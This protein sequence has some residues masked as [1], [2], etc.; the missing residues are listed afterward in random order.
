MSRGSRDSVL[1]GVACVVQ[2]GGKL[3]VATTGGSPLK[4]SEVALLQVD[5]VEALRASTPE[6]W[7]VLQC[8]SK[9][10]VRATMPYV[11]LPSNA[12]PALY[13]VLRLE[14]P[15]PMS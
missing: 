10:L 6:Q 11:A 14:I 12:H 15:R 5:S 3:L 7:Q 2:V 1:A 8:S 13:L 4:P 9:A